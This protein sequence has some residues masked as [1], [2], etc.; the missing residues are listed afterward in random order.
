M[1]DE[2]EF[3]DHLVAEASP[4]GEFESAMA[5]LAIDKAMVEALKI[6]Y[7]KFVLEEDEKLLPLTEAIDT[8]NKGASEM[9]GQ[10]VRALIIEN[11]DTLKRGTRQMELPA[12]GAGFIFKI[13]N[14]LFAYPDG[15]VSSSDLRRVS[16]LASMT[17]DQ[18]NN[19]LSPLDPIITRIREGT[20]VY[21]QLANDIFLIDGRAVKTRPSVPKQKAS[22]PEYINPRL[23]KLNKAV[24]DRSLRK[25]P[26]EA[27]LI[28]EPATAAET[29]A[30]PE[31]AENALPRIKNP[32]EVLHF[33]PPRF[34]VIE[35]IAAINQRTLDMLEAIDGKMKANRLVILDDYHAE[36]DGQP[37]DIGPMPRYFLNKLIASYPFTW[38]PLTELSSNEYEWSV[39]KA[40]LFARRLAFS[41]KVF[42]KDGQVLLYPTIFKDN[43]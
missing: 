34:A 1:P 18:L 23:E 19:R 8:H 12:H 32:H 41:K 21:F 40:E 4:N 27:P 43:R 42:Y 3:I 9:Y 17:I 6:P 16:S 28:P 38:L 26:E 25:S 37:Y 20:R 11:D 7:E 33:P 13:L 39:A 5:R 31:S 14:T 2:K 22:Q 10:G 30:T 15:L 29:E 36:F 35:N 24:K